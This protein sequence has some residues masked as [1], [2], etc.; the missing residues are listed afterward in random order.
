MGGQIVE[1]NMM[2]WPD[3]SD[4]RLR[5]AAIRD[6]GMVGDVLRME[7]SDGKAGFDY[8]VEIVPVGSSDFARYQALCTQAVRNSK[9]KWGYY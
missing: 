8:Y 9:K 4:F 3:K 7:K 2:T 1:V 5:S 6:A